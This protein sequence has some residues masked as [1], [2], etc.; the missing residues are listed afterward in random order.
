[1]KSGQIKIIVLLILTVAFVSYSLLLYTSDT[2]ETVYANQKALQGKVLW[3][4]KNCQACHQIYGLGGHL[5]PDL[6]NVYSKLP[7]ASLRAFLTSGTNVMPDF[8]LTNQQKD[9]LIEFLKYTNTTG[10]ADPN[11]FIQHADGTISSK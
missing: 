4:Q 9:A 1:M 3:Q 11:S 7:E 5:G 2:G 10:T 8:H 6:T